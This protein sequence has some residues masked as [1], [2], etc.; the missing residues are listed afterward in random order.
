MHLTATLWLKL[1]AYHCLIRDDTN[2]LQVT[3]GKPFLRE[4]RPVRLSLKDGHN[5]Q[6]MNK[7]EIPCRKLAGYLIS[8]NY[9]Y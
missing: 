8:E 3:F 4:W 7:S 2:L 1:V 6:D 5:Y 9:L